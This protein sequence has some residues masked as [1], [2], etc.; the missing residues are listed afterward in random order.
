MNFLKNEIVEK[1]GLLEP[2]ERG[3][4]K[5]EDIKTILMEQ[6]KAIDNFQD[7]ATGI[8]EEDINKCINKSI[9][10]NDYYCYV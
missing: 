5:C 10:Q 6:D 9:A 1:Y 8:R 3:S 4:Y 2:V 7:K